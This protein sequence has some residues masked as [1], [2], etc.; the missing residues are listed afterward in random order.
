MHF[1]SST[2]INYTYPHLIKNHVLTE[3]YTESL[4][5]VDKMDIEEIQNIEKLVTLRRKEKIVSDFV[6]SLFFCVPLASTSLGI[7]LGVLNPYPYDGL[8]S[9]VNVCFTTGSGGLLTL[10]FL[11]GY[12]NYR[13]NQLRK[14][15]HDFIIKSIPQKIQNKLIVL[16]E[17]LTTTSDD[18]KRKKIQTI[19]AILE[20]QLNLKDN[21]K[22]DNDSVQI[23]MAA[24]LGNS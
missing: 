9:F 21:V 22:N 19:T 10:P 12:T 1:L 20:K 15:E 14:S 16:N 23:V 5:T 11:K 17:L 3:D 4:K 8:M 24:D 2:P 18:N 7:F 6:F 13:E